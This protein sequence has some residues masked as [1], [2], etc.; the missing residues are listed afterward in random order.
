[1][2]LHNCKS[3]PLKFGDVVV[4]ISAVDLYS[5]QVGLFQNKI[6]ASDDLIPVNS[7][8]IF[9]FADIKPAGTFHWNTT[10]THFIHQSS[11]INVIADMSYYRLISSLK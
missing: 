3:A 1:M 5:S 6:H 11:I 9:L 4:L 2:S 10:S 8:L 7:P